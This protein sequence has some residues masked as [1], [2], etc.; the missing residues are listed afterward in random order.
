MPGW[1][2]VLEEIEESQQQGRE[3]IDSV[4]RRYLDELHRLTGRNIIAY[5][6]GWPA[7]R[8]GRCAILHADSPTN[9]PTR[10]A[11]KTWPT[12]H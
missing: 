10:G 6:S 2:T 1:N 8:P 3:A 7:R 5:Y 11:A 12:R 4:R 9:P